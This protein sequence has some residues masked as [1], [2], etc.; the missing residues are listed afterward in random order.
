MGW[1]ASGGIIEGRGRVHSWDVVED[2]VG[3]SCVWACA[4]IGVGHADMD[5][6]RGRGRCFSF[7]VLAATEVTVEESDDNQEVAHC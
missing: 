1:C 2:G 3:E 7:Q 5:L 4:R 6:L